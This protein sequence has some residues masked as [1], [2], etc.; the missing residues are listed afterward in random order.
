M[1]RSRKIQAQFQKLCRKKKSGK[2]RKTG[3]RNI[4]LRCVSTDRMDMFRN[5]GHFMTTEEKITGRRAVREPI[6]TRMRTVDMGTARASLQELMAARMMGADT[7]MLRARISER[8]AVKTKAEDTETVRMK[9]SEPIIIRAKTAEQ[10]IVRMRIPEPVT[11]RIRTAGQATA[12][13]K[14]QGYSTVRM[15]AGR[16]IYSRMM[17]RFRQK[18]R[19]WTAARKPMEFSRSFR[20]DMG[21]SA[22]KTFFRERMIFMFLRPRSADLI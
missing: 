9:M 13:R 1:K 18:Q 17:Q 2:K 10:A 3:R 7:E 5:P 12:R 21:L 8:T 11:I 19:S 16:R 20:T 4:R 22:V 14:I 15:R 6:I